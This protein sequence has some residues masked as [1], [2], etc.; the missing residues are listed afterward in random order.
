MEPPK[1]L[2]W[3]DILG[4]P[5]FHN[6]FRLCMC[7]SSQWQRQMT[8]QSL[9]AKTA[10]A[11]NRA[12][13]LDPSRTLELALGKFGLTSTLSLKQAHIPIPLQPLTN[14][15]LSFGLLPDDFVV[16]ARPLREPKKFAFFSELP[17][18]NFRSPLIIKS[19]VVRNWRTLV[20][21]FLYGQELPLSKLSTNMCHNSYL[22]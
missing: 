16:P 4:R 10:T 8:I 7:A 13:R 19:M 2:K 3:V 14:K 18:S 22:M 9:A 6:R 17:L 15:G 11:R 5:F 1:P 12:C 20:N 21:V